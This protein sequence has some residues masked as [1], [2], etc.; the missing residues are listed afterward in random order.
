MLSGVISMPSNIFAT[1]GT[2]VSV[3]FLDKTNS[4][5]NIVLMDVSKLGI[6]IKDGKNQKTVLSKDEENEIVN[7]FKGRKS[8]E[9]ICIVVNYEE[10]EEKNY[11]F[12]AG[13]YF[14]IKMEFK[15]INPQDFLNQ[16]SNYSFKLRSLSEKSIEV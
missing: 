4:N 10:I 1:T 11:S 8:K 5:G 12:S 6:T 13:K 9:G 2:N 16:I 3:I 7:V 15:E 14:Y